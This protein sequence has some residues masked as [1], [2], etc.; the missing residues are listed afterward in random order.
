MGTINSGLTINNERS[1]IGEMIQGTGPGGVVLLG[2]RWLKIQPRLK[3]SVSFLPAEFAHNF[4]VPTRKSPR[5]WNPTQTVRYCPKNCS[6]PTNSTA[7]NQIAYPRFDGRYLI[8]G[9]VDCRAEKTAT[10]HVC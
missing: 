6:E 5:L 1:H 9:R 8:A 3:T 4:R 2:F 7:L 10:Q